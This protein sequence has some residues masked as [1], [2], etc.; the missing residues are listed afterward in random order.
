MFTLLREGTLGD[1]AS[2]QFY[3]TLPPEMKHRNVRN[4]KSEPDSPNSNVSSLF[5]RCVTLH[6]LLSLSVPEFLHLSNGDYGSR[7]HRCL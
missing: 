1:K 7:V 2:Q 4:M 3:C 5:A 6:K